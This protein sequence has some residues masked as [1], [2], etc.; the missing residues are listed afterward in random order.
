[1]YVCAV[2][3][4]VVVLIKMA[5]ITKIPYFYFAVYCRKDIWNE[6]HLIIENLPIKHM[7]SIIM[8]THP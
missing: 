2:C 8:L 6:I 3:T 1:M 5:S 7:S 4:V